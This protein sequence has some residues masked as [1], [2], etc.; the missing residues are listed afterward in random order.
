[1]NRIRLIIMLCVFAFASTFACPAADAATKKHK[2][3][4]SHVAKKHYKKSGKSHSAKK[5]K[6]AS[7]KAAMVPA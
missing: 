7:A 2:A 1:M 6:H 5:A 4:S 3:K